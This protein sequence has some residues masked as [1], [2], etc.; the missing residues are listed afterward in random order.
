MELAGRLA[1][2]SAPGI[3]LPSAAAS[4]TALCWALSE[5]PG[6]TSAFRRNGIIDRRGD[7]AA[8]QR[9]PGRSRGRTREPRRSF[10][11]GT[12]SR[13]RNPFVPWILGAALRSSVSVVAPIPSL[14]VLRTL[15]TLVIP[16]ACLSPHRLHPCDRYLAPS[17]TVL[18]S[19]RLVAMAVSSPRFCPWPLRAASGACDY[20]FES[21]V[22][23]VARGRLEPWASIHRW[24][25]ARPER[26]AATVHLPSWEPP[27]ARESH[28]AWRKTTVARRHFDPGSRCWTTTPPK[29]SEAKPRATTS[30]R[31]FCVS[32]CSS[33]RRLAIPFASLARSIAVRAP[34][35]DRLVMA[36]N[37]SRNS[38]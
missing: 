26:K 6:S 24:T 23:E 5:A 7:F 2:A 9:P 34:S 37:V 20:A 3:P 14:S 33:L 30:S 4:T 19:S 31:E 13:R 32:Y 22:P 1:H 15:T 28:S 18:L 27:K 16:P 35:G 11:A 38:P 10:S 12:R 29:L 17:P 25:T 21:Q 36:A 8:A